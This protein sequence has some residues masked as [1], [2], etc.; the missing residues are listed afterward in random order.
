M[1][2]SSHPRGKWFTM[3][4]E[5][6]IRLLRQPFNDAVLDCLV[7]LFED[8]SKRNVTIVD[9]RPI[10]ISGL[11]N[12]ITEVLLCESR[13]CTL[14]RFL[15]RT[16]LW[17]PVCKGERISYSN[18]IP[19]WSWLSFSGGVE[20]ENAENFA[21]E[22]NTNLSF[23]QQQKEVVNADLAVFVGCTLQLEDGRCMLRDDAG[24]ERGVLQFDVQHPE[25]LESLHCIVVAKV[26]EGD[27]WDQLARKGMQ[28]IPKVPKGIISGLREIKVGAEPWLVLAVVPNGKNDEY[29]RVGVGSVCGD[30]VV[31]VQDLVRLV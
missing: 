31:K 17:M 1:N 22:R 6:P 13:F 20:F 23:H 8:Y 2:M 28:P 11:E 15:H 26:T 19:S 10:A 4:P 9:D 12:R 29:R 30:Y 21:F 7:W 25:K 24:H 5:F 27:V 18:P 16:L 14:E 3:D